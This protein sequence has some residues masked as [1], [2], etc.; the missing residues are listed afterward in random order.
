MHSG[1]RIIDHLKLLARDLP[2]PEYQVDQ[3]I[4]QFSLEWLSERRPKGFSTGMKRI[5]AFASSIIANPS[6]IILDEPMNGLEPFAVQLLRRILMKHAAQGGT[7]L[8]R[9]RCF[10][11]LVV[12]FS[13]GFGFWCV[14]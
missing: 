3:L 2:Y 9:L 10:L 7:W 14:T 1:R 4:K 8:D 13:R 11:M 6:V 5:V 12:V